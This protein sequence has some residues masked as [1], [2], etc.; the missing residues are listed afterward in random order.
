MAENIKVSPAPIQ[1]NSADVAMEL[2]NWHIKL[3][4]TN[5]DEFGDVYAKYYAIAETLS[6]KSTSDLAQFLPNDFFAKSRA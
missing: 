4:S 3:K 1:R 5:V 2:F 6:R